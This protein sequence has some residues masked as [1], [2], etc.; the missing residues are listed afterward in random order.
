LAKGFQYLLMAWTRV[1]LLFAT[2]SA[3]GADACD[4]SAKTINQMQVVAS[5]NSYHVAPAAGVLALMQSLS[6]LSGGGLDP[7]AFNY[8]HPP[9][10]VQAEQQVR[11]FEL[12]VFLDNGLVSSAGAP[13]SAY[14]MPAEN[15]GHKYGHPAS[16]NMANAYGYETGPAFD[17]ADVLSAASV[18]E[19]KVLHVPDLDVG[20]TC[21]TFKSCL[22]KLKA[23]HDRQ[24]S[25]YPIFIG[26]EPVVYTPDPSLSTIA[27][28]L[29]PVPKF[30]S[31]A[32]ML[33][34]DDEIRA[35]F[36]T[37]LI[38][39]PDQV[40]GASPTLEEAVTAGS[41]SGGWPIIADSRGK[42]LFYV[43]RMHGT[44]WSLYTTNGASLAGRTMFAFGT[45]GV[46]AIAAFVLESCCTAMNSEARRQAAEDWVRAG[47]M[48][49]VR[50]DVFGD[51]KDVAQMRADADLAVASGAQVLATDCFAT[52]TGADGRGVSGSCDAGYAIAV[53]PTRKEAYCSGVFSGSG[54]SVSYNATAALL[55]A[56]S[57]PTAS[58]T[59]S[60]THRPTVDSN[61]DS[62]VS[63][64]SM[65]RTSTTL[66]T[67]M[68]AVAT[69]L[70]FIF[71]A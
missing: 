23:W 32:K 7:S 18:G 25:H 21:Y 36:P 24:P 9:L 58:P 50:A 11:G 15:P 46:D 6:S 5:H 71:A 12:D 3:A 42:F 59:F 70:P 61:G 1:V 22:L 30:D 35:V 16:I 39:T 49:R 26:V 37:D 29:S 43:N 8:T 62:P 2:L 51:G 68:L 45:P 13:H 66:T 69:L 56:T 64:N 28:V 20:T 48:V 65:L 4:E 57:A 31:L 67:A 53:G 14:K 33:Q 63:S 47:Y 40:Q 27:N 54:S 19:L 41:A 44:A 38:I 17:P 52:S 10:S 34:I 55:A 60:P